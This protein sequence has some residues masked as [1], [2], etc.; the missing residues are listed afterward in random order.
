MNALEAFALV[1][2][3]QTQLEFLDKY[4]NVDQ[5]ADYDAFHGI[6]KD[7]LSFECG[8]NTVMNCRP[9]VCQCDVTTA[10][11]ERFLGMC[12][13]L[14]FSTP[15][16]QGHKIVMILGDDNNVIR[17]LITDDNT[18]TRDLVLN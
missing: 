7:N 4:L 12:L 18:N 15:N 1:D 5:R 3:K 2:S 11:G 10:G 16:R 8:S 14:L 6:I 13:Q 9:A 17:V